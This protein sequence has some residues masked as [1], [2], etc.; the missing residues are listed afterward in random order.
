MGIVEDIVESA[1]RDELQQAALVLVK[2]RMNEFLFLGGCPRDMS[3]ECPLDWTATEAGCRP[4]A[5]Y[6]G[7]CG[8]VRFHGPDVSAVQM[9]RLAVTCRASWPCKVPCSR[10][11]HGCPD[12]WHS[13]DG[14]CLAPDTYRGPCSPAV[15]FMASSDD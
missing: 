12:G 1:A 10:V 5:A 15:H 3:A 6:D 2:A 9:E 7:L 11:L 8:V 4:P 14:L 13:I